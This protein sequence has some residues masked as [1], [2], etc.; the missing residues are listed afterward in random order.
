MLLSPESC[1]TL[2]VA[3]PWK[4]LNWEAVEPLGVKS[5]APEVARLRQHLDLETAETKLLAKEAPICLG[6]VSQILSP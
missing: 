5:W 6:N 2:A 4:E 3:G 1:R